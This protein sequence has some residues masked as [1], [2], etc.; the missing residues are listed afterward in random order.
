MGILL[1]REGNAPMAESHRDDVCGDAGEKQERGVSVPEIMKSDRRQP[2]PGHDLV[3]PLGDDVGVVERPI[4][5]GEYEPGVLPLALERHALLKLCA[6]PVLEY[7]EG[8]GVE[9][10]GASTTVGLRRCE[11]QSTFPALPLPIDSDR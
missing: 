8:L 3:E 10:D 1:Q 5:T 6:S 2:E 9:V 7:G 4:L 11:H